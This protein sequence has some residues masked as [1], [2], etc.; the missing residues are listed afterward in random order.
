M[1]DSPF[2]ERLVMSKYDDDG[3]NEVA[4]NYVASMDYGSMRDYILRDITEKFEQ[5]EAMFN[6]YNAD[7]GQ[8]GDHE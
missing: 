1:A 7:Y 3:I 2:P 5:D 8:G 4:R 6:D